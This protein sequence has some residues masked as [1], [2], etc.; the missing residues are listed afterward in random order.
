MGVGLIFPV[1]P[2]IIMSKASPFFAHTVA[3]ESRYFYY[4]L[5]MALWP[6]G[7]FIGSALIGKLSDLYGRKK[8]LIITILGIVLSYA[9]S[10]GSFYS[11][12]LFVFLFS[13]FLCG[14]FGGSFSLA[15]AFILDISSD[16]RRMRNLGLITLAAS[17]GLV[18]GPLVATALSYFATTPELSSVLP[19]WFGAVLALIN[20]LNIVIFL[21]KVPTPSNN[22]SKLNILKLVLSF[23]VMFTDKRVRLLA[24][25]FLF[26]QLG[27]GYFA[28][29]LPLALEQIFHF[30]PAIVGVFFILMNAGYLSSTLWIQ[31]RMLKKFDVATVMVFIAISVAALLALAGIYVSPYVMGFVA[32]FASLIEIILYTAVMSEVAAQVNPSEQGEY[33]GGVTSVFGIAWFLN[34]F[35]MG[36]VMTASITAP[37][38]LASI[39]L[40]MCGLF[41]YLYKVKQTK[42]VSLAIADA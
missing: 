28:Q 24:L 30:A 22:E 29:S 34:A 19:F 25:C 15:Q 12:S 35:S 7:V 18:I 20:V 23:S 10:I 33:M 37:F 16:D 36:P 38:F 1:I 40:L 32:F 3:R 17:I 11:T 6:L 42:S 26:L 27:W 14:F 9:L 13:R 41:A 4:G 2:E 8:L 39:G 31:D 5:S 21:P